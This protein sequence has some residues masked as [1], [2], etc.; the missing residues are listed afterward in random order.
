M[1]AA[2]YHIFTATMP[3]T[4]EQHSRK[5]L[6]PMTPLQPVHHAVQSMQMPGTAPRESELRAAAQ[7]F[8]AAFLSE[9]LKGAGLGEQVSTFGGGTGETQFASF[10]REAQAA[11]LA[12]AGGIGIAEAVFASLKRRH[13]GA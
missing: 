2:P 8:E 3:C 9:M 6:Q 7:R 12:Q 5:G 11:K 1:Q 10:L 4:T 13:H